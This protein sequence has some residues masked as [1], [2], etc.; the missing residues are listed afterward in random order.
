M[1][2]QKFLKDFKKVYILIK[3]RNNCLKIQEKKLYKMTHYQLFW[4]AITITCL[5]NIKKEIFKVF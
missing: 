1:R 4:N 2:W 3:I 5:L